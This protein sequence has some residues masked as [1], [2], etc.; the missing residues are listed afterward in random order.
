VSIPIGA[1]C[2][3]PL[4]TGIAPIRSMI[5]TRLPSP[6]PVTLIWGL[7]HERDLYYQDEL[8]ALAAQYPEF[9]YTIT[10]S[11]PSPAWTGCG[12]PRAIRRGGAHDSRGRSRGL[13]V[14]Q[15]GDDRFGHGVDSGA[16][17]MSHSP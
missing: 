14:W 3:W 16:R 2:L 8:A 15:P 11:Q 12:R 9:S 5:H 10:L 13:R 4:E 7:R 1:C 17:D 6:T